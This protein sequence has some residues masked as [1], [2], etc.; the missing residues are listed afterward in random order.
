MTISNWE[1]EQAI[2]GRALI[3]AQDAN[4]ICEKLT[5]DDFT[6]YNCEIFL[7]LHNLNLRG[8][9][10]DYISLADEHRAI[11]PLP[12]GPGYITQLTD[13]YIAKVSL[14]QHIQTLKETTAA[15]RVQQA[16]EAGL[17]TIEATIEP[18]RVLDN[19]TVSVMEAQEYVTPKKQSTHQEIYERLEDI[20][21]GEREYLLKTGSQVLD[22]YAPARDELLILAARPSMGK[23]AL[24]LWWAEN[25]A[26]FGERV[27]FVSIE[28]T[29]EAMTFR[30]WARLTG[31]N[32]TKFRTKGG[33]SGED[34]AKVGSA[35]ND[36]QS[37]SLEIRDDIDSVGQIISAIQRNPYDVVMVDYVQMM[38][39]LGRQEYRRE[40]GDIC[41][42]L[43]KHIAKPRKIPTILLSQLKRPESGVPRKP[44]MHDLR[45]SGEL[46]QHADVIWMLHKND[47]SENRVEVLVRKYR[48]G[49]TGV[50]NLDHDTTTGAYSDERY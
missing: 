12:L 6:S 16:L 17:K 24:A 9:V 25:L 33:L 5:A 49:A 18:R 3:D 35:I 21:T 45:E 13:H 7:A 14:D 44:S 29:V 37:R 26:K 46:E 43:K 32:L 27:L 50:V 30:R 20:Q 48:N 39:T 42:H 47:I 22:A 2:L 34:W 28:M 36:T 41:K 31:I 19:L 40:L 1:L 15:R 38:P 8:A 10:I 11:T 23:T 4:I